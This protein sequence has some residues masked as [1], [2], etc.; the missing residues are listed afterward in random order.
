MHE[1][2]LYKTGETNML[3]PGST[4]Y[5]VYALKGYTPIHV[6]GSEIVQGPSVPLVG[7]Q[8]TTLETIPEHL[9]Y[10]LWLINKVPFISIRANA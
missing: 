10:G 1:E 7:W 3:E 6:A 4:Y 9:E 2:T 8:L 5:V